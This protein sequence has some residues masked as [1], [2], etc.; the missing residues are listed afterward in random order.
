MFHYS[1]LSLFG[2][3]FS[4]AHHIIPYPRPKINITFFLRSVGVTALPASPRPLSEPHPLLALEKNN[5]RAD[6]QLTRNAIKRYRWP[7]DIILYDVNDAFIKHPAALP[8]SFSTDRPNTRRH[9]STPIYPAPSLSASRTTARPFPSIIIMYRAPEHFTRNDPDR[10]RAR[11]HYYITFLM[12][13]TTQPKQ[14]ITYKK[15]DYICAVIFDRFRPYFTH[16]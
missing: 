11:H 9:Y 4:I 13:L 14:Y 7:F 3:T 1:L 10:P 15:S 5:F 2:A 16:N 8:P 6:T 12:I